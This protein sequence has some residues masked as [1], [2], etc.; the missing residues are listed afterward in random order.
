MSTEDILIITAPFWVLFLG[1][2][3]AFFVHEVNSRKSGL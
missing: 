2:M 1:M 3:I